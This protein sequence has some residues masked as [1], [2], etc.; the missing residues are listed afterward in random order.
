[1]MRRG[2]KGWED[3]IDEKRKGLGADEREEKRSEEAKSIV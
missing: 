3:G 1:M 2:R